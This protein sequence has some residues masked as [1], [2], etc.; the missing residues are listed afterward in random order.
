[1]DYKGL[2]GIEMIVVNE[3]GPACPR[4]GRP[5]RV[6]RPMQVREHGGVRQGRLRKSYYFKR[7]VSLPRLQNS[8]VGRIRRL[9]WKAA[10][11][12]FD[13]LQN[14]STRR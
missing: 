5:M 8:D 10:I 7:L 11:K 2:Q 4:Y 13:G 14:D 9:R 12:H 6:G 3:A 1:M